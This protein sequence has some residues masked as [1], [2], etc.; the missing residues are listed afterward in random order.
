MFGD[1]R[2]EENWEIFIRLCFPFFSRIYDFL[3]I[4]NT[5]ANEHLTML[6]VV[7]HTPFVGRPA[8]HKLKKKKK[9]TSPEPQH[10]SNIYSNLENHTHFS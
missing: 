5:S 7:P 2:I 9:K 10:D 4:F 1:L 3:I 8:V 6:S